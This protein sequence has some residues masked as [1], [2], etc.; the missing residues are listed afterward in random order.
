LR[1]CQLAF[2]AVPPAQQQGTHTTATEQAAPPPTD[3]GAAPPPSGGFSSMVMLLMFVPLILF[4]FWQ[5]RSQQKKQEAAVNALKKG[6][7]VV[8]QSGL[9]GKL[10]DV[11][12][13]YAKVELAPGVK[14]QVLRTSLVG[15]DGEDSAKTTSDKTESE[16]KTEK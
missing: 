5:S 2:Q 11:D 3:G 8:T 16:K 12:T 7:R 9:I 10:L 15:R 6:D 1:S 4:L 13:R 14:V